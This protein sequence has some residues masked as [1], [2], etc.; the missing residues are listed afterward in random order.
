MRHHRRR[1]AVVPAAGGGAVDGAASAPAGVVVATSGAALAAGG[2]IVTSTRP[3]TGCPSGPTRRHRIDTSPGC[4]TGSGVTTSVSPAA[5]CTEPASS[6][7]APDASI[8]VTVSVSSGTDLSNTHTIWVG[9]TANVAPSAGSLETSELCASTLPGDTPSRVA[10]TPADDKCEQ[11]Q[12]VCR[13]S[14]HGLLGAAAPK[15]QS[16]YTM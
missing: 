12:A 13:R 10:S 1:S 15:R 4:K 3:V 16:N 14:R 7:R 8:R 9:A 5:P 6:L 11:E 2:V